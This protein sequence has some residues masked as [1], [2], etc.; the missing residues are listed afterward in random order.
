LVARGV[1]GGP[2]QALAHRPGL[3]RIDQDVNEGRTTMAEA[4][5]VRPEARDGA[6]SA[7]GFMFGGI[8]MDVVGEELDSRLQLSATRRCAFPE[9]LHAQVGR[10]TARPLEKVAD[11]RGLIGR[12]L[13]REPDGGAHAG[14]VNE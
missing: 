1:P 9:W 6:L 11:L 2:A 4:L 13:G 5:V 14:M 10:L 12:L 8:E 3:R 7:I